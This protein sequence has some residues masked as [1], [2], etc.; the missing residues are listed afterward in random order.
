[1]N[2]T[3]D[4]VLR[5]IAEAPQNVGPAIKIHTMIAEPRDLLLV[6]V[7][8]GYDPEERLKSLADVVTRMR[9]ARYVLV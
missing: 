8:A 3:R 9:V 5:Y 2:V 1:M 4:A 7:W 6:P